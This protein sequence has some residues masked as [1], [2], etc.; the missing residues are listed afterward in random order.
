MHILQAM[1]RGLGVGQ[2]SAADRYG[3]E[4]G[5]KRSKKGNHRSNTSG[6][7]SS[8]SKRK[9]LGYS[10]NPDERLVSVLITACDVNIVWLVHGRMLSNL[11]EM[12]IKSARTND[13]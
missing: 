4:T 11:S 5:S 9:P 10:S 8:G 3:E 6:G 13:V 7:G 2:N 12:C 1:A